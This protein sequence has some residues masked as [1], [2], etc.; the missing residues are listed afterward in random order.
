MTYIEHLETENKELLETL[1]KTRKNHCVYWEFNEYCSQIG[2]E[3]IWYLKLYGCILITILHK[4]KDAVVI[5]TEIENIK[6]LLNAKN[7]VLSLEEPVF[8]TTQEAKD[9]VDGILS[10]F[11]R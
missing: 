10:N 6:L 5:L 9:Y 7:G 11:N 8:S 3:E 2:Y 4:N 1:E